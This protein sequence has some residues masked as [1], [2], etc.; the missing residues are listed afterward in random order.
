MAK[1]GRGRWIKL[2]QSQS[3]VKVNIGSQQSGQQT[4]T[5]PCMLL[6]IHGNGERKWVS[7]NEAEGRAANQQSNELPLL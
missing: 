7:G 3:K 1:E 2:E 6:D 5:K 4:K